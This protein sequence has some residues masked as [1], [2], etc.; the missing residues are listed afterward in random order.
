MP[1]ILS[2]A[3]S[4]DE[5]MGCAMSASRLLVVSADSVVRRSLVFLFEAEGFEVSES[6]V[7]PLRA[8]R[9]TARFDC[10]ILDQRLLQGPPHEGLTYCITSHPVVLL[11]STPKTWIVD[12]VSQ[13]VEMP[14]IEDTLLEAVH[15]AL[16][17]GD[18]SSGWGQS[19][20]N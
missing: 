2:F 9:S 20:A 19:R 10:T 3:A 16:Q 14:V 1:P 15:F 17:A 4:Y 12:W 8:S 18:G 11:A 13:V 5:T 7:V 6:D